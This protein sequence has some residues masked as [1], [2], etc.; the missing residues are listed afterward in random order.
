MPSDFPGSPRLLKGALVVFEALRPVPTN[1]IAFQYN[2][3]QVTRQ[4][5]QPKTA[6]KATEPCGKAGD[7]QRVVPPTESF[8]MSVELDATDQLEDV[9]PLAVVA[10]LHPTLSALELLLYPPST[11]LILTRVLAKLGSARVSPLSAPLVLLVWGP[12]RVVPVQVESV[13][14]TEQAF[15]TLLNPVRAKVDLGLRTLSR[16]EL[17]T[18]G[19]PFDTLDIVNQIAKEVLARTAPVTSVAQIGGSLKLF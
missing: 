13:A 10:G 19:A 6:A 4:Y 7:T 17:K 2:P 1:I 12:L 15:D 18:L 16:K 9:S 5:G 11:Q 14:I 8:K 3:D